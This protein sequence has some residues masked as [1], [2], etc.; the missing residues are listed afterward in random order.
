MHHAV[1][2]QVLWTLDSMAYSGKCCICWSTC[3]CVLLTGIRTFQLHVQLG[4]AQCAV[5]ILNCTCVYCSDHAACLHLFILN[6]MGPLLFCSVLGAMSMLR[7]YDG[8]ICSFCYQQYGMWLLVWCTC[9]TV[10]NVL[11]WSRSSSARTARWYMQLTIIGR[12]IYYTCFSIHNWCVHTSTYV[13]CF[14]WLSLFRA[15]AYIWQI[16]RPLGSCLDRQGCLAVADSCCSSGIC[17]VMHACDAY[18]L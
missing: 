1:H 12:V 4:K 8:V 13:W 3:T 2:V 9:V 14:V 18:A 5:A 16:T 7:S 17:L 10:L 11:M 15:H 6:V